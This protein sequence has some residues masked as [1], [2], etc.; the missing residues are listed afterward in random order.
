M[1]RLKRLIRGY[2]GSCARLRDTRKNAMQRPF[3]PVAQKN[4]Y[5]VG[6]D[7]TETDQG[8]NDIIR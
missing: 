7:S 2:D 5:L 1:Y 4:P 8:K 6:P 3:P